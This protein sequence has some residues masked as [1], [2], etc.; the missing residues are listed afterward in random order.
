[1][2]RRILCLNLAL[3]LL[4]SAF[5]AFPA[6]AHAESLTQYTAVRYVNTR[7]SNQVSMPAT[8]TSLLEYPASSPDLRPYNSGEGL[9]PDKLFAGW[10]TAADGTGVWYAA[11]DLSTSAP[12]SLYA[13]YLDYPAENRAWC[14]LRCRSGLA[15]GHSAEFAERNSDGSFTLP[16]TV[17]DGAKVVAWQLE[18]YNG[19]VVYPGGTRL[20]V[21]DATH[22]FL[23]AIVEEAGSFYALIDGGKDAATVYGSRY[24][25]LCSSSESEAGLFGSASFTKSGSL[26]TGYKSSDGTSYGFN[27]SVDTALRQKASSDRRVVSFTAQYVASEASVLY[28]G[29]GAFTNGGKAFSSV[30]L[31]GNDRL[32]GGALFLAPEGKVFLGWNT[33]PNGSG[34]WYEE[35]SEHPFRQSVVLY[36]Q[37]G[38]NRLICSYGNDSFSLINTSVLPVARSASSDTASLF[39]H[40][41]DEAGNS[42]RS[43]SAAPSGVHR[44]T[45]H[46]AALRRA[47]GLLTLD[48]GAWCEASDAEQ[49]VLAR[50]E[51]GRMV[52][53]ATARSGAG[54]SLPDARNGELR[55]FSLDGDSRPVR[56]VFSVPLSAL[57]S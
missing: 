12:A 11:T 57:F 5:S 44:L 47:N 36:A 14:V 42:Y 54:A 38:T 22:V 45:G 24:E 34:V 6:A 25:L 43:G 21:P 55:L 4:L 30:L 27:D 56:T 1:M 40:W 9:I 35:G 49:L 41:E 18:G 3:L 31:S 26:L 53:C 29:N 13:L 23:D 48:T 15:N 37:W 52:T 33:L 17:K 50:F 46:F 20:I 32:S 7:H 51:D 19:R 16:S 10:N 39:S 8:G 28:L 2:I